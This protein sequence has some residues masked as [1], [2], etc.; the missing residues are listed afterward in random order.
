MR[1]SR[2]EKAHSRE[3]IIEIAATRIREAGI[4]GPGVAEIMGAAGMTHGGFYKHFDSRDDLVDAALEHAM[5]EGENNMLEV[6][7]N[8]DDPLAAWVDWYVSAVH[9]ANPGGGCAVA[10]LGGDIAHARDG[11]RAAY[12]LQVERYLIT[13]EQLLGTRQ[14]ATVALATAIGAVTVARAI[15]SPLLRDEILSEVRAALKRLGQAEAA[16][17]REPGQGA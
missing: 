6:T 10:A 9:V 13:L 1:R 14:R 15:D 16:S 7:S 5:R 2:E 4:E 11:L 3:R 8:A 17:L 12:Q